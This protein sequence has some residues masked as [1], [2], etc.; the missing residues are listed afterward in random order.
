M[1]VFVMENLLRMC[2]YHNQ[3]IELLLLIIRAVGIVGSDEMVP[4][5]RGGD[6]EAAAVSPTRGMHDETHII[7]V[8]ATGTQNIRAVF[9]DDLP[10]ASVPIRIYGAYPSGDGDLTAS[11]T[12]TGECD[13]AR[14]GVLAPGTPETDRLANA[15]VFEDGVTAAR[16]VL[17]VTRG[18]AVI[19][20]EGPKAQ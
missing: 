6:S 1:D 15:G 7:I 14:C 8:P 13:V 9:T 19:T 3:N 18:V 16:G 20:L 2:N 10:H 5:I 17:T 12:E 11:A 4:L